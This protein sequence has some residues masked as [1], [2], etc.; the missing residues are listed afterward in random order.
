ML[1]NFIKDRNMVEACII[2]LK[3]PHDESYLKFSF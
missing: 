1:N 3:F 2:A